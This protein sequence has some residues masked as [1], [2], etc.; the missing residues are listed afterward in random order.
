MASHLISRCL[1]ITAITI[2]TNCAP[3]PEDFGKDLCHQIETELPQVLHRAMLQSL[4][5]QM[6]AL[7][8]A[9]ADINAQD[10]HGETA[11][12]EAASVGD[13]DLVGILISAG[14][15]VNVQDEWGQTP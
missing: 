3:F 1:L 6:K 4:S 11:L 8:A 15:D 12:H 13:L 9:G 7:R 14:A 2:P 10:R 5:D